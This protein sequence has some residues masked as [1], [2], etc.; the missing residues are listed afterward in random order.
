MAP[1]VPPLSQGFSA[2]A[3]H[4]HSGR[5][6]VSA[7]AQQWR[8]DGLGRTSYTD[9][10]KNLSLAG[11]DLQSCV[12]VSSCMVSVGPG[13]LLSCFGIPPPPLHGS[14]PAPSDVS[15]IPGP[16]R[17]VVLCGYQ[18]QLVQLPPTQ[19]RR[20][21]SALLLPHRLPSAPTTSSTL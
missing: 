18:D 5:A 8:L 7:G 12:R 11:S 16:C 4:V 19:L 1:C 13:S 9:C 17:S 14:L 15:F 20:H 21:A 10:I 6:G 3:Q 2:A